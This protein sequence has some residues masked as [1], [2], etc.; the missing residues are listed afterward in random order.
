[1]FNPPLIS[2]HY[3]DDQGRYINP[4][5]VAHKQ[6]NLINCQQIVKVHDTCSALIIV[7]TYQRWHYNRLWYFAINTNFK[8][9]H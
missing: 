8:Q 7:I 9:F 3:H 2:T 6:I 1:M 5:S 4:G